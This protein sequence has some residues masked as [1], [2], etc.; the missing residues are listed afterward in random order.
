MENLPIKQ[1]S[2]LLITA[3]LFVLSSCEDSLPDEGSLPDKTPPSANFSYLIS[4]ANYQEFTFNNES[5]SAT[6]YFWDFGDG[7][8]SSLRDPSHT[9]Q[10]D[11][12]F[13]VSLTVMDKN[14]LSSSISQ[15]I[16]IFEP[17]NPFVPV[18]LNSGFDDEGEDSYRDHWRNSD[19]G[20]P[21]QI[22]SNPVHE[23][24][25]A[26]KLPSSG[27]RIAYQL[28]LVEKEKDY[29][30]SFHYTLK[31]SPTGSL[32]FSLLKEHV[33]D[34]SKIAEA[35]ITS[36]SFSDQSSSNTYVPASIFFNSGESNEVAIYITN[37]E[38]E[39]RIDSFSIQE[40]N[41]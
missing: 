14:N 17:D 6:D 13:E 7:E 5:I 41:N 11:G 25:K 31:E 34:P 1:L 16:E 19:L 24:I 18:I 33:T 3:S 38:V 9:Y 20:G 8:T 15:T 21:I 27:E 2:A 36:E 10:Q 35:T 29:K 28:I 40:V 23:G 26:G 12:I 22:S 4:E 37:S 32:S 30:I 39:G